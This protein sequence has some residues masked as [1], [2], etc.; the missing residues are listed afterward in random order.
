MTVVTASG[1]LATDSSWLL[2]LVL[3]GQLVSL[4]CGVGL[5]YQMIREPAI[6]QQAADGKIAV[7]EAQRRIT[8]NERWCQRLHSAQIVIFTMSFVPLLDVNRMSF[9]A[10]RYSDE[11]D[12]G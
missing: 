7:K 6:H 4:F 9:N 3:V 1:G 5:L 8:T 10:K 2:K 12:S 11:R